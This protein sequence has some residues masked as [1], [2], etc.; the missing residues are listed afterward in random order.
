MLSPRY[1][2]NGPH[3][4]C[5]GRPYHPLQNGHVNE[6]YCNDLTTLWISEIMNGPEYCILYDA[7]KRYRHVSVISPSSMV[8]FI[9]ADMGL[10]LSDTNWGQLFLQRFDS[11]AS[12][13]KNPF[14]C[15]R[16]WKPNWYMQKTGTFSKSTEKINE[17]KK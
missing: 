10:F 9:T 13:K 8:A 1:I 12:S 17:E 7:V 14:N 2:M 11:I 5:I 15:Q 16:P 6:C 3:H 4:P